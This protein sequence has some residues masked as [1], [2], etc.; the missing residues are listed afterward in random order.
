MANE[1]EYHGTVGNTETFWFPE[2]MP[3]GS[4]PDAE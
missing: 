4:K 3:K 1:V 2:G